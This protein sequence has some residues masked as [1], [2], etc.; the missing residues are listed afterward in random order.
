MPELGS[1]RACGKAI[2]MGEHAVVYGV[3]ALA[4]PVPLDLQVTVSNGL[5]KGP[6][7]SAPA[8]NVKVR[9]GDR[10]PAT[11]QL[12]AALARV[13]E[14]NPGAP[15]ELMLEIASRIPR[16]AGL[17]S[18]AALSVALV[19]TL[20]GVSRKR[21]TRNEEI[22]QAMEI[23]RVFHG[24]PSGVDHSVV[25]LEKAI[26]FRKGARAV[27]PLKLGC[28]FK[29]VVA[30]VGQH[31][32]TVHRVQ[33]LAERR[34]RLPEAYAEL[35]AFIAKLVRRATRALAEGD[36]QALGTLLDLNQ[37]ALNALGVSS[38]ELEKAIDIARKAGA[39]GAKLSGAGGGG[40]MIALCDRNVNKVVRALSSAGCPAFISTLYA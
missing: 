21:L 39:L 32:G 33:A 7:L 35:F 8:W 13:Y 9:L 29:F 36:A 15:R 10:R 16:S 12:E 2:I 24:N 20:A 37:G 38:P 19:R 30:T 31:G 3:P 18:S 14:L 40:A 5:R 17:G 34:Q 23:E 25:A 6:V 11:R 27:T 4:M 1:Y 22:R 26:L 28:N